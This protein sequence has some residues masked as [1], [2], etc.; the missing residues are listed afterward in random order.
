MFS[1]LPA[2]V[3]CYFLFIGLFV[4]IQAKKNP[5]AKVLFLIS[6]TTFLWQLSWSILFQTTNPDLAHILVRLGWSAILFLPTSLYHFLALL[7]NQKTELKYVYISYVFSF[8]LLLILLFSN[9]L[10]SGTYHYFFGLYPKAGSWHPLH[11]LQ[12]SIVV[13]RGL[14]LTYQQQKAATN[15]RSKNQLRY[16]VAAILI[17][18]FA[19]IDYLCNYGVE[20]YPVGIFFIV[21]SL[22]IISYTIAKHKL[23]DLSLTIRLTISR[24]VIYASFLMLLMLFS[25]VSTGNV[26]PVSNFYFLGL[27]LFLILACENYQTIL[28]QG[29]RLSD[30]IGIKR[31]KNVRTQME[32]V[33]RELGNST[34]FQDLR[35]RLTDFLD[36][37]LDANLVGFY[38]K[39]T[40]SEPPTQSKKTS[41]VDIK[42]TKQVFDMPANFLDWVIKEERLVEQDEYPP[43]LMSLQ[44]S[45]VFIPFITSHELVGFALV[46]P[47]KHFCFWHYEVFE[48]TSNHIA[49]I[50]DRIAAHRA[51]LLKEQ[52]Y[53][54]D[55]AESLRALAGSIAHEIR[56]PLGNLQLIQSQISRLLQL[57]SADKNVDISKL[58]DL[59][60]IM[61]ESLKQAN[62]II[63]IILSDLKEEPL[64]PADLIVLDGWQALSQAI[65]SYGYQNEFEKNK[66][67]LP[68][69]DG[70]P[71]LIRAVRE[72]LSFVLYN[73]IKNALYYT[74]DY[75]N[76]RITVGVQERQYQNKTYIEIYVHDTG[77]GVQPHVIPHLFDDFFT[78]GKKGGSGLGLSFCRRN[79]KLFGG[80]IVCES[81]FG[82]WT[83]F[84]LLFPEVGDR[85]VD[86]LSTTHQSATKKRILIIDDQIN[87]LTS[88]R[89]KIENNLPH[90][91]C[92][93]TTSGIEALSMLNQKTYALVLTD[94]QMPQMDGFELLK[95][96]RQ[97]NQEIPVIAWT[98]LENL[99]SDLLPEKIDFDGY[100]H[101]SS[102][103]PLLYRTINKWIEGCKDQL[104]YL[105]QDGDVLE[106]RHIILA[107]DQQFNRLLF[108]S[109]LKERGL[110]VTTVQDGEK[111]LKTYQNSLDNRGVSSFDIIVTDI[112]MESY[113]GDDAARKIR[114]IEKQNQL[115]PAQQIPIVALTGDSGK[116]NIRDLLRNQINDFFVKGD[117]PES[118]LK[119]LSLY[120]AIKGGAKHEYVS[121]SMLDNLPPADRQLLLEAFIEDS[122]QAI[123]ELKS[124][125]D[126]KTHL[127]YLHSMKGVSA[128]VG[129]TK[130]YEYVKKIEKLVEEKKPPVGWLEDLERA[131]ETFIK[132][133]DEAPAK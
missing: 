80:E 89:L 108:S 23:L 20:I 41:Y 104:N 96:I 1:V 39:Q 54:L 18:F 91:A 105:S 85:A 113:D 120:V 16:C 11:V 12:T 109:L 66:I 26:V 13:L 87:N 78:F 58:A 56:N 29:L 62:Q 97:L 112:H 133:F 49:N 74:Q 79:M 38:I 84:S 95:K 51:I 64:N 21:I 118:L 53:L 99:S 101:K 90:M 102:P 117:D 45:L 107:D 73:L 5:L 4:S 44:S 123:L 83:R 19:A 15:Y 2:L 6:V 63:D 10:I 98:S 68:Q 93:V 82:E 94:I 128:T 24:T 127:F 115:K 27:F 100:V 52:Q 86:F 30:L 106:E 110:K 28:E 47:K 92:D 81:V 61:T 31:E 50:L 69:S 70:S 77:P 121:H 129:A 76:A 48:S 3:A 33:Y 40:F 55:K 14:Y 34:S 9:G 65:Q 88:T 25:L 125:V 132:E 42:E 72:R 122:Q 22:T 46:N 111:L 67:H 124:T 36:K 32:I 130:L 119:I 43:E 60:L 35:H 7:S 116:K 103:D 71:K 57:A 126:T 75:P 131:Y 17:Y 8:F 37:D 114:S 59:T